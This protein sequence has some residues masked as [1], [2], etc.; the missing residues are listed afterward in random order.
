MLD[1]FSWHLFGTN[2]K[3][4]KQ[5][6]SKGGDFNLS[7]HLTF[8]ILACEWRLEAENKLVRFYYWEN[9]DWSIASS[10]RGFII[11]FKKTSFVRLKRNSDLSLAKEKVL[12]DGG[13]ALWKKKDLEKAY[14]R[15]GMWD[16]L[17]SPWR[18]SV[19][20]V[21]GSDSQHFRLHGYYERKCRYRKV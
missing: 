6:F 20:S 5:S 17:P 3:L 2:L 10:L 7:I 12:K 4:F 11:Q 19:R 16:V 13:E 15:G 1:L 21:N 8:S 9:Q 18:F 14:H